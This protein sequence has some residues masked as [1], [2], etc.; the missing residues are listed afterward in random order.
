MPWDLTHNEVIWLPAQRKQKKGSEITLDRVQ[1]LVSTLLKWQ[2]SVII[3]TTWSSGR[4]EEYAELD[5]LELLIY[6]NDDLDAEQIKDLEN[7]IDQYTWTPCTMIFERKSPQLPE[8]FE[9]VLD[10]TELKPV[11]FPSRF[12]DFLQIH[13]SEEA[14]DE[15]VLTFLWNIKNH[16]SKVISWWRNRVVVHKKVSENWLIKWKWEEHP[17]FDDDQKSLHYSKEKW[18]KEVSIKIWALRYIQYQIVQMIMTLIRRDKI[19]RESFR[20]I[21]WGIEWKIDYLSEFWV[22]ISMIQL[23]ELKS[24]YT[25][26]LGIHNQLSKI[27]NKEWSGSMVFSDEDYLILKER[28]EDFNALMKEFKLK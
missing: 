15:L 14:F 1:D 7:T 10:R 2:D 26:F 8:Y 9:W 3:G 12:I 28:L 11:F 23:Q 20:D 16:K 18:G 25:F 13:G 6:W 19:D 24:L 27:F 17:L 4:K 21:Q 22:N 5:E